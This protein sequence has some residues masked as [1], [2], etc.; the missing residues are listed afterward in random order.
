MKKLTLFFL[1]FLFGTMQAQY[2]RFIY[3]YQFA[4]D[5]TRVDSTETELMYLDIAPKGSKFYSRI[6]YENDSIRKAELSKQLK[7]T[8]EIKL[9]P[10]ERAGKIRSVVEKSYP[11]YNVEFIDRVGMNWLI[12][13]DTRPMD[14]KILSDKERIGEF[15]VQKATLNLYGRKWTAMHF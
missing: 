14:W 7:M 5:S 15:N 10:P 2:Q 4:L 13:N 9:S 12:V 1:I 8:G 6:V 11:N 3:E